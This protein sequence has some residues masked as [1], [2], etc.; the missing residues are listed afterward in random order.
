M[1]NGDEYMVNFTE[2]GTPFG[3][4]DKARFG[5]EPNEVQL[6]LKGGMS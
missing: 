2:A 1:V 5:A 6:H 4:A 3:C